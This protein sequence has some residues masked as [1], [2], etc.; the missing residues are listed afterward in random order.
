[1]G[2]DSRKIKKISFDKGKSELSDLM[3]DRRRPQENKKISFDKGK[4][5]LSVLKTA[6]MYERE[7]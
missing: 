7:T 5:E 6:D 3:E 1:M 2:G 4:S